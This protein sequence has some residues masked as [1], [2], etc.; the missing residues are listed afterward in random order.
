[1]IG[2]ANCGT[3]NRKGSKYCSNCGQR[4]EPV[5]GIVCPACD[6]LNALD[7]TVCQYCGAALAA[8]ALPGEMAPALAAEGS[9]GTPLATPMKEE[10][11]QAGLES[12]KPELPPW[13]YPPREPVEQAGGEP[14]VPTP[15]A[16]PPLPAPSTTEQS[17]SK[18]LKGIRGVLPSADAWLAPPQKQEGE[19]PAPVSNGTEDLNPGHG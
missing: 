16:L 2:C 15:V 7:H 1:M 8:P 3:L 10:P 14:S 6:R 19:K 18:Y 4:L 17:D 11:V 13:L 12:P 9:G 5:S